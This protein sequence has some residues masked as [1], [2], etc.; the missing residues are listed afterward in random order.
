MCF[1]KVWFAEGMSR[2]ASHFGFL[3]SVGCMSQN[4]SHFGTGLGKVPKHLAQS[5]QI[6]QKWFLKASFLKPFL[7]SL[8]IRQAFCFAVLPHYHAKVFD[9]QVNL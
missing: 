2:N 3:Q 1:Y 7:Q 4:A 9:C 5:L 8:Y 6:L